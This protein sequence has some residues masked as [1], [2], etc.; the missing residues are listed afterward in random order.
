MTVILTGTGTVVVYH[1]HHLHYRFTL[2]PVFH[3]RL[4]ILPESSARFV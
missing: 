4:R 2:F 3:L 1:R